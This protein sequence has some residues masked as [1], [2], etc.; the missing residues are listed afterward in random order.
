[1]CGTSFTIYI[2]TKNKE[3]WACTTLACTVHRI[4]HNSGY[5]RLG[6]GL[7][8]EIVY[9]IIKKSKR[10]ELLLFICSTYYITAVFECWL[11]P[12]LEL[13]MRKSTPWSQ[14]QH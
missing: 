8:E 5:M 14:S 2:W 6:K 3:H 9:D 7:F 11:A 12:S 1:M 13:L 4:Y 10:L